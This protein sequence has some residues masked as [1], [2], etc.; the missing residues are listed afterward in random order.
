MSRF[1]DAKKFWD[2][3]KA[4]FDDLQDTDE[5]VIM[6]LISLVVVGLFALFVLTIVWVV[7]SFVSNFWPVLVVA[8]AVW[9]FWPRIKD[10]F[11]SGR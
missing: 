4:R 7:L 11:K 5:K 10:L 8:L 3:W 1:G 9:Y 6:A 2:G